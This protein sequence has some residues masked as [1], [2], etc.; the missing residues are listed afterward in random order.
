MAWREMTLKEERAGRIAHAAAYIV[1]NAFL[2]FVNLYTSPGY[3]W[4]PFAMAGWGIGLALHLFFTR[5]EYVL[6]E[7]KKKEALA[8]KIAREKAGRY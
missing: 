5:A 8:E 4:F 1:V 3:L 6:E 2:I 7:L